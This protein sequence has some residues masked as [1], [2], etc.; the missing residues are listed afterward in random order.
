MIFVSRAAQVVSLSHAPMTRVGML[1]IAGLR[2]ACE[3]DLTL[4]STIQGVDPIH[5]LNGSV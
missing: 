2:L 5:P 3:P 1:S 4:S